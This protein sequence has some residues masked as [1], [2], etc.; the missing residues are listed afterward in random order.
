M[1]PANT[2][3]PNHASS[4]ISVATGVGIGIGAALVAIGIIGVAVWLFRRKR[5][6]GECLGGATELDG[7]TGYEVIAPKEFSPNNN[8]PVYE[9]PA[10]F[11]EAWGQKRPPPSAD[12][13]GS[14]KQELPAHSVGGEFE[15]QAQDL[16]PRRYNT[17]LRDQQEDKVLRPPPATQGASSVA[18]SNNTVYM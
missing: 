5:K 17:C 11:H 18:K 13:V 2:A 8:Q 9:V 12:G 16:P 10:P 14:S 3:A 6:T 15:L 7:R 1:L 4:G